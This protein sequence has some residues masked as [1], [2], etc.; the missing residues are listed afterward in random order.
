MCNTGTQRCAILTHSLQLVVDVS[1]FV[2]SFSVRGVCLSVCLLK[3]SHR[4]SVPG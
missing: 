4:L 1:V 2:P 3:L